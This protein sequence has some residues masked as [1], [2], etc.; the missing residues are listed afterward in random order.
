MLLTYWCFLAKIWRITRVYLESQEWRIS[1]KSGIQLW[2]VQSMWWMTRIYWCVLIIKSYES[3]LCVSPNIFFDNNIEF[4]PIWVEYSIRRVNRL[5]YHEV[6]RKSTPPS[7]AN[8]LAKTHLL[9][10]SIQIRKYWTLQYS[11]VSNWIISC[12]LLQFDL[13]Q[14]APFIY[15]VVQAN[16]VLSDKCFYIVYSWIE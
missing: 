16:I 5:K 11:K 13:G 12:F 6:S 2:L 1:S 4:V 15:K 14:T 3:R 9:A 10:F 8:K 7:A